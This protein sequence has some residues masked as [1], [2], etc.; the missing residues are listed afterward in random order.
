DN[1]SA[2]RLS[3]VDCRPLRLMVFVLSGLCASAA[4]VIETSRLS[5]GDPGGARGFELLAIAAA[6]IG[7][8]SLSGGRG[9]VLSTFLGVLI[10]SVL[11]TG[12]AHA[13]AG[14]GLRYLITGTITVA[15]VAVDSLRTRTA[16]HV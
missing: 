16:D 14:E 7:G 8:T 1:E 15:A 10:I 12:L 4:G 9:S 3:G 13:G 5:T 6:V 2:L 11:Q